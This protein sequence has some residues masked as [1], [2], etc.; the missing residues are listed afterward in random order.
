[1][2]LRRNRTNEQKNSNNKKHVPNERERYGGAYS[3][4][5]QASNCRK[6]DC[7]HD[8]CDYFCVSFLFWLLMLILFTLS[9]EN[10]CVCVHT[11]KCLCWCLYLYL[12]CPFD[13][14]SLVVFGFYIYAS[15]NLVILNKWTIRI[16][17][18][19]V[20]QKVHVNLM[21]VCTVYTAFVYMS[22]IDTRL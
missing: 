22:R 19:V 6:Y 20:R 13:C 4:L 7:F 21:D 5:S 1:M 11:C 3:T 8:Y 9:V 15:N 16:S 17:C 10:L 12:Y 2:A 14:S 18:D